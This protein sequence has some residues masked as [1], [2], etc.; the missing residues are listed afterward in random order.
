MP[1]SVNKQWGKLLNESPLGCRPLCEE[2]ITLSKSEMKRWKE[3]M[4][5]ERGRY[6]IDECCKYSLQ[7]RQRKREI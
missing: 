1:P 4:I 7:D 5:K 3:R 6:I 2:T